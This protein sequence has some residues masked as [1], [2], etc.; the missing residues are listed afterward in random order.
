MASAAE[1]LQEIHNVLL[2][3]GISE[4]VTCTRFIGNEGFNSIED[5]SVMDGYTDVQEVEKRLSSRS[6]YTHV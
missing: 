3:W 5:F 6:V 2:L 1:A 4:R